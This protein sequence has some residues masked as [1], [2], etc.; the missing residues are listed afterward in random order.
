MSLRAWETLVQSPSQQD[1]PLE[2]FDEVTKH[3]VPEYDVGETVQVP[4][5]G[6]DQ[7]IVDAIHDSYGHET[8][9]ASLPVF[10]PESADVMPPDI[11]QA[12][13][14]VMAADQITWQDSPELMELPGQ[15]YGPSEG[16]DLG[17]AYEPELTL[18]FIP[19]SVPMPGPESLPLYFGCHGG[20][21]LGGRQECGTSAVP[22]P[23]TRRTLRNF[24]TVD[25]MLQHCD[26]M[27]MLKPGSG[28][29]VTLKHA[30]SE[31]ILAALH[32]M[33][34]WMG[35]TNASGAQEVFR[36][37]KE[38]PGGVTPLKSS[39]PRRVS[40][41]SV[42]LRY[43]QSELTKAL[44]EIGISNAVELSVYWKRAPGVAP[45]RWPHT[46]Y[47]VVYMA[48][49][50]DERR[51]GVTEAQANSNA[52]SRSKDLLIHCV[53]SAPQP[54]KKRRK[55]RWILPSSQQALMV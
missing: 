49:L 27:K 17:Q 47:L 22:M 39:T 3:G 54:V 16:Q 26:S 40:M 6:A 28:P 36:R 42:L 23:T 4:E 9:T 24:S 55:Q 5:H 46:V 25:F 18:P 29:F 43:L 32:A 15:A 33:L 1:D 51:R 38:P 45:S 44:L 34:Q 53:H 20:Y 48:F 13:N 19:Q 50:A 2:G 14:D 7:D 37:L 52:K 35:Y 11:L 21:T 31:L 41:N 10:V 8:P 12:W 30:H